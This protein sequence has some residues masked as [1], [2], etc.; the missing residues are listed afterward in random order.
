MYLSAGD[1]PL[2][3][4]SWIVIGVIIVVMVLLLGWAF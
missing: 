1:A 4:R 3:R 2:S